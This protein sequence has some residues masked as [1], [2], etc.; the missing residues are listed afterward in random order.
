MQPTDV[1]PGRER[2]GDELPVRLRLVRVHVPLVR[3]HRS[4]H[5]AEAVRDVVL[6]EWTRPDGVVGW[7]ECPTLSTPGYVTGTTD[8]AWQAL[9]ATLGPAALT[10]GSTLVAGA[11]AAVG[12]LADARLDAALRS[13]QVS[14]VEH[15]GATRAALVRC[16]VLADVGG[17]LDGLG[18]R[19]RSEVDGGAR[20]LKVKIAP[21]ADVAPLRA[22]RDAVGDVPLA[23][24]A[25]GSYGRPE[26]LR[27]V[28]AM[29]LAYLEQPF[30]AGTTWAELATLHGQLR[31]PV[32]L[33]ESLTSPD[34]VHSALAAD[35]VD[36]V[37]VKPARLGGVAAAAAVVR[38]TAT[39]GRAAFVG[40]MLEL[41]VG[42]AGAAA[43]AAMPGCTLPTD[44]GPSVTYVATDVCE[45]LVVDAAGDLLVP[46]GAGSGRTPDPVRLAEVTVDE[47]VLGR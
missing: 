43:V 45:P 40:G 23:A 9:V 19:A 24:D 14:L 39:A 4:A 27:K 44:L 6:V 41:G 1:P 17:D 32:A 11:T 8:Q 3:A 36:V 34:A 13:A 18:E 37:S 2:P 47:V 38:L 31:T 35:A 42:R 16:A 33:D 12:A 46:V 21:G 30:A 29:G 22:V 28:D 15:L 5:G 25:N 20:M 10:G 7:G 26:Q